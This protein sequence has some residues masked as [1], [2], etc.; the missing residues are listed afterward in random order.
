MSETKHMNQDNIVPFKLREQH[1]TLQV[2]KQVAKSRRHR[3][4][5]D[6]TVSVN[7]K[8]SS[9]HD[10]E[11]LRL[12]LSKG[13]PTRELVD[14]F[15]PSLVR[16]IIRHVRMQN[17]PNKT[18]PKI[19]PKVLRRQLQLLIDFNHPAGLVLKDWLDGNRQSLLNGFEETYARTSNQKEASYE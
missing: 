18:M 4:P 12:V 1:R 3:L 6:S 2:N 19:L 10:D 13:N 11:F 5:Q 9:K 15:A 14:A 8:T 16:R 17:K 7:P